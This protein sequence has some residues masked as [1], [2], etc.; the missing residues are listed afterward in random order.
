MPPRPAAPLRRVSSCRC[1]L[2]PPGS[3]STTRRPAGRRRMSGRMTTRRCSRRRCSTR[4]CST[5]RCSTRR[6][7]TRRCSTRRCSRT[8]SPAH[9]STSWRHRTSRPPF[10]SLTTYCSRR[11][12]GVRRVADCRR[13]AC[14]HLADAQGVGARVTARLGGGQ[15]QRAL[16]VVRRPARVQREQVGRRTRDDGGGEGGARHPQV[17]GRDR[18]APDAASTSSRSSAPRRSCTGPARRAPACRKPSS[19]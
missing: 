15:H 2:S 14:L 10:E 16:D 3:G 7:S 4:R 8:R 17:P 18:P 13:R 1:L 5:R 11:G 12:V 6:C 19:V 9:R